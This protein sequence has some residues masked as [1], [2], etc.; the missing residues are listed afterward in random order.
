MHKER[1]DSWKS[2]SDYLQRSTR[3][4]QRWHS[5]HGLP[6]HHFRGPKGAA[7]AYPEEIDAWLLGFS[8]R[9]GEERLCQDKAVEGRKRSLELIATANE[10]WEIR[11]EKNIELISG[12]Y[13]EAIDEDSGNAAAYGGLANAM[14][15]VAL[16]GMVPGSMA[17]P[18]AVEA[19]HRMSLIEPDSADRKCTAAWLDLA[20]RRKWS[21]ART[22]F[23]VL[24]RDGRQTSLALSGRA[25]LY[26][27][28][29]NLTEALKYAWE[30]WNLNT[31]ARPMVALLS[32]IPY[33]AGD[34]DKSLQQTSDARLSGGYGA[35]HA[36]IEALA[37]I[38]TGSIAPHLERLESFACDYPNDRTLQGALGY[39]YAISDQT[40]K[41]REMLDSLGWTSNRSRFNSAY[42]AALVLIGLNQR[43][44]AIQ[45]LEAS[46]AAGSQWSF[47]FR[48]D[49][50]LKSL[51]GDR[52]FR[53]FIRKISPRREK[54][55]RKPR[56]EADT[57]FESIP[58]HEEK[59]PLRSEIRDS[60]WSRHPLLN[61]LQE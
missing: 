35:M 2:I 9:N 30:A 12:L 19:L 33:L 52:N 8:E 29:G 51:R 5:I 10:M 47:G 26:V 17:Y 39:F 24:L 4:V 23:D 45:S 14:V 61:R 32:W 46:Y 27:A 55:S 13:R 59:E 6:V 20:W 42:A 41:A 1:L 31:L 54:G 16:R 3:T 58:V 15:F 57:S 56:Q 48:S 11:S 43:Q 37:L 25:L 18:Q 34:Y 40:G 22:A 44:E 21:K 60:F 50:I 28:E 49:P 7:F 38:E 36:A 53:D